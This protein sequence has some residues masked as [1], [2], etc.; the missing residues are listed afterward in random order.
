MSV[1]LGCLELLGYVGSV[2]L[3]P[4]I[5]ELIVIVIW[6]TLATGINANNATA[7]AVNAL[8]HNPTNA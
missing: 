7:V 3:L 5:M 8:A 6:V 2:I 4:L 1:I